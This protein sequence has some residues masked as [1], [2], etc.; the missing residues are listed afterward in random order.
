MCPSINSCQHFAE[1]QFQD[2]TM[3]QGICQETNVPVT[4]NRMAF[5]VKINIISS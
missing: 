2:I 3:I 4:P 5:T 1:P